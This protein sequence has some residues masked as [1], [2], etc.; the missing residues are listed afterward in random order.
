[1]R[2]L[3]LA[4]ALSAALIGPVLP[5]TAGPALAQDS[6]ADI[7]AQ[8]DAA[9]RKLEPII[10]EH[11][12]IRTELKDRQ[13]EADKLAERIDPLELQL[14]L[15]RSE[16]SEVAVRSFKNGNVSTFKALLTTGSPLTFAE[17]LTVLDRFAKSQ[18]DKIAKV[19][20]AKERYEA[21]KAELDALVAELKETE[22][23]L[24]E[25]ADEIDADIDELQALHDELVAQERATSGG[26]SDSGNAGDC[27]ASDPGGAAGTAIRFA[28]AQIGKP[29]GWGQAGPDAYDCS[30]LTSAAWG[31]AGISLPHNAAQQRNAVGYVERSDL[32]VGDLVFYYSDL[33]HI[34][35]YAG[36]GYVVHASRAGV[37][38]GMAP[39][40]QSPV[41]SYGRPG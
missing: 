24:A 19:I 40:D 37:P 35:M 13:R 12:G 34:G 23:K 27:P 18:Q 10:E 8:I 30:G 28:C 39:I 21:E 11:N 6:A 14:E 17:Q 38:V 29:Y 2:G 7:E 16:V 25:R 9:W 41:H 32:R 33:S 20:E 1:L 15:A 31:Q 4:F 5:L 22:A 36:G 26:F 3:T